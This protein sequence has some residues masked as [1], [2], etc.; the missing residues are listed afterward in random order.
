MAQTAQPNRKKIMVPTTMSKAGWAIIE[1]RDDVEGVQFAPTIPNAEFHQS[2]SK[3]SAARLGPGRSA[4]PS[5][6]R[7]RAPVVARI[8]VGYDAVDVPALTRRVPLMVGGTANS[9]ASPRRD[10]PHDVLGAEGRGDGRAV[11]EGRWRDRYKELPM[12]SSARPC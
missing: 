2:A 6:P 11:K 12:I 3:T 5:S 10:V 7:R 8:G 4:S 9:V 1:A